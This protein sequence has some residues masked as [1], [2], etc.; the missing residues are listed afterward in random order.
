MPVATTQP[1]ASTPAPG[2]MV[3]SVYMPKQK[4]PKLPPKPD[5]KPTHTLTPA[6]LPSSIVEKPFKAT[7]DPTVRLL[8]QAQQ[9]RMEAIMANYVSDS[10]QAASLLRETSAALKAA[11]ELEEMQRLSAMG[12]SHAQINELMEK[13]LAEISHRH[14]AMH[15]THT[16]I[17]EQISL[18]AGSRGRPKEQVKQP[19]STHE[20]LMT[21]HLNFT[22]KEMNTMKHGLLAFAK[23][24]TK[25]HLESK[26]TDMDVNTAL[27]HAVAGGHQENA[28]RALGISRIEHLRTN[29][30]Y[31]WTPVNPPPAVPP[32]QA[33]T[34]APRPLPVFP[35]HAPPVPPRQRHPFVHEAHHHEHINIPSVESYRLMP[36]AEQRA[37]LYGVRTRLSRA[38]IDFPAQASFATPLRR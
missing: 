23:A 19:M 12:L 21:P 13:R 18:L 6:G 24:K 29:Y 7:H 37:T 14:G 8:N 28:D 27:H 26:Q 3:G 20:G 11:R 17:M 33:G 22:Q 25:S 2:I 9:E 30:N 1:I 36:Q 38:G 35:R 34:G 32:P 31:P 16:G 15:D 4:Q 5:Y 10:D